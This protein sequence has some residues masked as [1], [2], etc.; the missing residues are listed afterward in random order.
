VAAAFSACALLA[1]VQPA[2]AMTVQPVVVDLTPTG[3]QMTATV[4]VQNT[5]TTPLPVELTVQPLVFDEN[6]AKPEGKDP[7]DLLI[8]PPQ[9]IV[10]PGQTQAF[11]IQ[12]VGDPQLAKSRHYYVTVAQLPVKLPEGQS[13]IQILYNFQVLVNV[14]AS[15]PHVELS[16]NKAEI[17]AHP[18]EKSPDGKSEKPA[19][20]S[21]AIWITNSGNSYGYLSQRSMKISITDA[22]GKEVFKKNYSPEEIQQSIGFGVIGPDTTRRIVLP[23]EVPSAQ[24]TVK[25]EI[26]DAKRH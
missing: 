4:S 16:V 8:F 20:F 13:A 23:V 7:G 5:F 14:A 24:G 3:R 18:A 9:T 17:V 12:W 15:S 1:S 22:A 10:A 26:G 2:A 6:G 19:G 11:R 25:A 21:P